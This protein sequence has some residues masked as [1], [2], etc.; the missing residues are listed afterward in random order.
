MY[1]SSKDEKPDPAIDPSAQEPRNWKSRPYS[2]CRTEPP[3]PAALIVVLAEVAER[4]PEFVVAWIERSDDLLV[5]HRLHPESTA[6]N[7]EAPGSRG[8]PIR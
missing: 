7:F 8:N 5:F 6:Y 4:R 1:A 3:G 2:V